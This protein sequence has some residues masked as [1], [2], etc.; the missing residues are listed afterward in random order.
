LRWLT[1]ATRPSISLLNR[2][3]PCP[4][5]AMSSRSP[6]SEESPY[7][8][9]ELAGQRSQILRLASGKI[10]QHGG[11]PEFVAEGQQPAVSNDGRWLA[12]LRQDRG[13]S[14]L[15]LSRD[16]APPERARGWQNL[17]DVLEMTVTTEGDIIAAVGGAANLH[18][19]WLRT[20]GGEA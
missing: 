3:C 10:G 15:W 14:A 16:G 11:I 17:H 20:S 18:L 5:Q 9:L 12:F 8:Y 13:R 4:R 6:A 1:E 2:F 7:I 19:I